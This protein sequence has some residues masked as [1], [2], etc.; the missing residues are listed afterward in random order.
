[1]TQAEGKQQAGLQ[2]EQ[3]HTN[4]NLKSDCIGYQ[5]GERLVL[6]KA[7]TNST[8]EQASVVVHL[9]LHILTDWLQM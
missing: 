8:I 9:Q 7:R 1:M 5:P 2:Y 4:K 6:R 3:P